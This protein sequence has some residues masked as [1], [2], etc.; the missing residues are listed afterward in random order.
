MYAEL[1]ADGPFPLLPRY[2]T[3]LWGGMPIGA[4]YAVPLAFRAS[5]DVLR[6]VLG[7]R[8]AVGFKLD[9]PEICSI[10]AHCR[11]VYRAH[12]AAVLLCSITTS[13]DPRRSQPEGNSC[14]LQ[15]VEALIQL[16]RQVKLGSHRDTKRLRSGVKL[17]LHT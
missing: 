9:W 12:R 17:A 5:I 15:L 1:A 3:V 2:S 13:P 14:P 6:L 4:A 7:G 8:T 11:G 10:L 16:L